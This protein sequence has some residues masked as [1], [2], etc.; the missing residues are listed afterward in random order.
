MARHNEVIC[1]SEGGKKTVNNRAI[2]YS[3]KLIA[4]VQGVF[5]HNYKLATAQLL[6]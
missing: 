4:E 6:L 2:I 1:L 3:S 5:V